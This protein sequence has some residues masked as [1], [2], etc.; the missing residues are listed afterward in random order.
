VL[1]KT[2]DRKSFLIPEREQCTRMQK[3]HSLK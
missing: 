2:L 3:Y 1:L